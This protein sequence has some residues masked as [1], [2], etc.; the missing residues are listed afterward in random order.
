MKKEKTH[1]NLFRAAVAQGIE[2]GKDGIARDEKHSKGVGVIRGF[3]VIRKG[4][5]KDMRGWE[6]DD[7]TLEQ[8]MDLGNKASIGLKSRFGHPNMSNTALGTFLGRAQKFRKDGDIV[9]A[10]LYLDKTAYKTPDGDL[11]SYVLDL[12]ES[13]PDAYGTS[14]VFDY[15]LEYR[16]EKDGT[17]KK[18][19]KT[20]ETLPP[21]SRVKKLFAVD[22]VDSPAATDGMLSDSFFSESVKLSA[23]ATSALDKLL[24][25]PDA[26]DRV[27]SF[28]E[29]YRVNLDD[30]L[31]KKYDCEC[32]DCK[33][34]ETYNDHC[35]EHK[36]PECG[37]QMRRV[38]RPGPGQGEQAK[39]KN[40]KEA[41]KMDLTALTLE[42]LKTEKPELV[43]SLIA[44]GKEAGVKEGKEAGVKVERQSILDIQAKA[45]VFGDGFGEL[46]AEMVESGAAIAEA[47]GK[48]KDK[49]IELLQKA[50]PASPGPGEDP[51]KTS[52]A[53]AGLS[54]KELW[55]SQY[56]TDPK[57]R[58]E[59]SSKDNYIGYMRA[60]SKGRVKLL[61]K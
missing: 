18:D 17:P 40:E 49:K 8:V 34:K 39:N 10:D 19:P 43:N 59:F 9:R 23:E 35:A 50:A 42:M 61:K 16:V 14:I 22:T 29:R 4:L 44:E 15:N 30:V 1:E 28:L 11:A 7:T 52:A 26:I 48:F 38:E 36:C 20:K 25:S 3:A 6:I 12:A 13:D 58:E 31:K 60:S 53:D 54:G 24:G 2:N 55:A 57:I 33:H 46:S 21:L 32:V 5:V 41:K 27:M 47:E 37:G 45:A 51:T 56:D